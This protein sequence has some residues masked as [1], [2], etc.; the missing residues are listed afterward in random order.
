MQHK[1]LYFQVRSS[2]EI[3]DIIYQAT[4]VLVDLQMKSFHEIA[5][6]ILN[7]ID[8]LVPSQAKLLNGIIEI[9]LFPNAVV[10]NSQV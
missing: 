6:V 1:N 4:V 10:F 9:I 7:A 2:H 8:L 5:E 3:T